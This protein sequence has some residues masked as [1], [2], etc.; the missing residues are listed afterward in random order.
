LGK[1]LFESN[2]QLEQRF[3]Y[4]QS[5]IELLPTARGARTRKPLAEVIL[6]GAPRCAPLR[7]A[8]NNIR[9]GAHSQ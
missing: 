5:F 1:P 4:F 9:S 6:N 8:K 3:F 2:Q 7:L